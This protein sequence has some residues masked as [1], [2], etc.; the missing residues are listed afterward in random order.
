M[1]K[2]KSLLVIGASSDIGFR[3]TERFSREDV[4]IHAHYR[5]E[6]EN[7]NA[8]TKAFPQKIF[9]YQSDLVDKKARE[10]FIKNVIANA[11]TI[12]AVAFL[13]APT[14]KLSR[15]HDLSW[16]DIDRHLAIQLHAAFDIFKSLVPQMAKQKFGRNVF[17]L[18]S[19]TLNVPPKNM[20]DYVVGKF[21]MLGL[22]KALAA[23]YSEKNV[24]FNAISPSMVK[25]KYLDS[26]PELAVQM[27]MQNHP[28]TR[29]AEPTE[30]V[31]AI[32][33]L[34]S[35]SDYISGVN[36]PLAGGQVY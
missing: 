10:D 12:D 21:A 33:F 27:N 31:E 13:A 6:S 26:I 22:V 3:L 1:S 32:H 15:F 19:C 9:S 11:K 29:L 7:L 16:E 8:L 14:F 17:V 25:T 20:A 23:E 34:L 24:F 28:L 5:K 2:I 30:V 35:H 4:F 36:L 18:S